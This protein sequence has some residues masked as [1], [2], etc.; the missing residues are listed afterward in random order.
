[1]PL[2]PLAIADVPWSASSL[3]ALSWTVVWCGCRSAP[4]L[5][6]PGGING[7]APPS[8]S[9]PV[10]GKGLAPGRVQPCGLCPHQ[11]CACSLQPGEAKRALVRQRIAPQSS[12]LVIYLKRHLY[13]AGTWKPVYS[14]LPSLTSLP[15][16][17][18]KGFVFSKGMKPCFWKH[19]CLS[20]LQCSK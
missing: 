8:L 17:T 9:P 16:L 2:V 20:I 3:M 19:C 5:A 15:P 11:Q 6:E 7:G 10:R 18:F 1:M 12:Y 13:K 14:L 4:A